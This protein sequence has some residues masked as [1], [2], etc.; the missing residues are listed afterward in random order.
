MN[1]REELL[2]VLRGLDYAAKALEDVGSMHS[3]VR[4]RRIA[5]YEQLDLEE[6]ARELADEWNECGHPD[7]EPIQDIEWNSAAIYAAK[8]AKC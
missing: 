8:E 7:I 3:P 4:A 2:E 5:A 1:D 6:L